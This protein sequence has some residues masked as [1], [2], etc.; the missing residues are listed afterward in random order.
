[1]A[2]VRSPEI[3]LAL[4][5][6]LPNRAQ[7]V[8]LRRLSQRGTRYPELELIALMPSPLYQAISA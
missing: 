6:H 4:P 3:L 2:T 8:A 7:L 5:S 1:M